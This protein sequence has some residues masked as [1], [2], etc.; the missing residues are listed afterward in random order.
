MSI[1]FIPMSAFDT[2]DLVSFLT[3]NHS[4]SMCRQ[5]RRL[6]KSGKGLKLVVSGMK[7]LKDI[8]S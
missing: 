6:Q 4:R 1:T 7:T 8:G 5:R 2:E 3:Q